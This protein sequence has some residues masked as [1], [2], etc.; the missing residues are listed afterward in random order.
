MGNIYNERAIANNIEFQGGKRTATVVGEMF[1]TIDR[2]NNLI[3]ASDIED[4][5][6]NTHSQGIL[7]EINSSMAKKIEDDLGICLGDYGVDI[8]DESFEMEENLF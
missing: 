6:I 2:D 4:A 3:L 1:I 7:R 8:V 5:C